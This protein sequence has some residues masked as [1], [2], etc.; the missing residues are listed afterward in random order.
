VDPDVERKNPSET[1]GGT[2]SLPSRHAASVLPAAEGSRRPSG[3]A[4]RL[5][6]AS[7]L[8]RR[9]T[10]PLRLLSAGERKAL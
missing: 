10:P 1:Q 4:P 2:R 3:S 5:N 9:R 7:P 8:P 6:E